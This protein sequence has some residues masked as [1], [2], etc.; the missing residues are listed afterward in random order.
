MLH[1][2]KAGVDA[3]ARHAVRELKRLRKPA[4]HFDASGYFRGAPDLGFYNVKTPFV[5]ALARDIHAAHRGEWTIVH[6]IACADMLIVDR[7]LEVKG[8]AVELVARF[9][10]QFATAHLS[11]WKR[12]LADDPARLER[13]LLAHGP[14]IPRTTLRYAIERFT[15][16]KRASLLRRTKS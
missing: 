10:P 5:R 1:P 11:V 14:A 12:W 4:H 9:R 15:P 2:E 16:E 6:A 8:V 3:A 7:F 13:Y